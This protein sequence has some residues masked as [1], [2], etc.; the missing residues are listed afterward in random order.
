MGYIYVVKNTTNGMVYVGQTIR[1]VKIRWLEHC[2][3]GKARLLNIAIKTFGKD[4]FEFIE[5]RQCDDSEL[6]SEETRSINA[7]NSIH[8]NGYNVKTETCFG[9]DGNSRG[10]SSKLGHDKQSAIMKGR[11]IDPRLQELGEIPRGISYCQRADRGMH[12]EGFSV[13]MK[14]IPH[15]KF[16]SVKG[17]NALKYN[18]DRAKNYLAQQVQRS[19]V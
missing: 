12:R 9:T 4:K 8:P 1:T 17:K 3:A 16:V 2:S 7:Y 15:K 13:R 6:D 11:I 14:G 19:S 10:G 5:L 18:L